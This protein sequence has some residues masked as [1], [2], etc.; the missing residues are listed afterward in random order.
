[1][2]KLLSSLLF[3]PLLAQAAPQFKDYPVEMYDG[4]RHEVVLNKET[5]SFKTIFKKAAKYPVNFAGKYVIQSFGCGAMCE[6]YMMID[7]KTGKTSIRDDLMVNLS[8]PTCD[9]SLYFKPN[10]LLLVQAIS[11]EKEGQCSVNYYVEENG[12]LKLIET[13]PFVKKGE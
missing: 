11:S 9:N 12:K 5:S 4:V 7:I 13:Q 2:K 10:S 3:L 6:S 1:M 8:D